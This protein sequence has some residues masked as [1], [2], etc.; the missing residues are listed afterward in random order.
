VQVAYV[1]GRVRIIRVTG[2]R[3]ASAD[4]ARPVAW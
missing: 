4:T 1:R 3:H 2:G